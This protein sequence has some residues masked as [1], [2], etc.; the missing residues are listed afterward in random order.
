MTLRMRKANAYLNFDSEIE[1][2]CWDGWGGYKL[3]E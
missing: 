3:W 1:F 2:V